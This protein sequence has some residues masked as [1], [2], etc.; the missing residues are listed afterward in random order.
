LAPFYYYPGWWEGGPQLDVFVNNKAYEALSP[1]NQAIVAAAA[2]VAHMDIQAKYDAKNPA[3]LKQ[4]VATGTKLKPFP[5]DVMVAAFK[6]TMAFYD[7]ISAKNENW[8][9]VYTD[10]SKFRAEQ[11]MWFKVAESPFDN[12]M[13]AQKF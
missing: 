6:E 10:F 9:K 8:K 4:L 12:F 7:E 1:E 3:A 5:K 13:Q 11:N 2:T